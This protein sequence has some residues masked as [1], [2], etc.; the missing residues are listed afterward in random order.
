MRKFRFLPVLL[1]LLLTISCLTLSAAAENETSAEATDA[2]SDSAQM[3]TE[4]PQD[5]MQPVNED[6]VSAGNLRDYNFTTDFQ[7]K[8]KAA[9][10]IDLN[11]E[12]LIYGYELDRKI[13]PASLTKIMTCI[14][15]I[16]QGN[17]DDV[18]TVSGKAL[19]NLS[20][21]G[22]SANLLAGEQLTLRELLYCV[23]V[24]SANEACNVAAEYVSGSVDAF[25][26]LMNQKAQQLGMTST[27]YANTHGL[28]DDNHF[29]T[30]RDLSVLTRYAW[31]N[32]R[33][34][35]FATCTAH[36]VPAT[37]LSEERTLHTTNYL[38]STV[39]ES[40]Y[41]Y[42]KASGVKTGFTTPAGSCLISTAKDGD[43]ELLSIV[44]GCTNETDGGGVAWDMRFVETKRLCEY[45]FDNF[46]VRQV[47]TDTTML[48]QPTVRYADGRGSVVV[49][50]AGSASVLLPN[51]C[52]PT[53]VTT[54]LVYDNDRLEAPLDEGERVGTVK[55]MYHGKMI[56][57]S[58]LVTLTAVARSEPKYVTE[59]TKDT[60]EEVSSGLMDYW[61]VTLPAAAIL[62]IVILVVILR[63]INRRKA[64]KRAEQRRRN[65]ARRR[66]N[67]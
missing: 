8:A 54:E 50:A 56:A 1:A 20:I 67:V 41:Y 7:I 65:A 34:R 44:C 24:S 22:S 48:G 5:W 37:N 26:L 28:H 57:S 18:V 13:Y 52:E 17:L 43:M 12:T 55:V 66:R 29:T 23:M 47:L 62:L 6:P 49:R 19:E 35:E 25:V 42:E 2:S 58:D 59:Q 51:D 39:V 31:K 9:A 15:A 40:K 64:R 63:A 14:L 4:E 30:V 32:D 21:Y 33:F 45:G 27:H 16:E 60:V 11:T 36:T 3:P 53:E 38:T 61:Y 10:L 46:S